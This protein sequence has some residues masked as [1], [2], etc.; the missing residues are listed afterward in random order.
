M[1]M[2][3]YF[4]W[5][6]GDFLVEQAIHNVDKAVLGD[7]RRDAGVGHRDGRPRR[8][9]PTAKFGNIFD[10]FTVVYEYASG[11]K[12]LLQC[13]QIPGCYSDNNDH[14]YG[15]KGSALL[16][17]H[18][19]DNGGTTWKHPGEHNFGLMYQKE[20]DELFA[21]IRA[22]KPINDG[23]RSAMSTLMGIMGREAAYTGQKITWKQMLASKQSLL[24]KEFAWGPNPVAPVATPGK[25]KFV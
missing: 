16:M 23:V 10:H 13:R 24:P 25:T 5:L 1:R 18:S 8:S 21:A 19:I 9:A 20:H 6:S 7:G 22:G 14:I 17:R 2:W 3:Y 12:V 11:A 15:T 4:T